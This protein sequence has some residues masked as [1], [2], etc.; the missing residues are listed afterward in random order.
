MDFRR[1]DRTIVI[2]L[3]EGEEIVSSLRSFCAKEKVG[4][5]SVSGIGACRKAEIAHYDTG[6]KEYRKKTY[7]G[8]MEIVSLAGNISS[9]DGGPF[10][11]LHISLGLPDF[12]LVGGHL[13]ESVVNPTCEITLFALPLD[14]E[15]KQDGKSALALL[16]F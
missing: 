9:K 15:R 7:E 11:H 1:A 12:S 16:K 3:D 14:M 2:R 13:V 5:A 4:S 6:R 10:P 8:M